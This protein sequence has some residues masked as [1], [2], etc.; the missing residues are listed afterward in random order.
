[1]SLLASQVFARPALLRGGVGAYHSDEWRELRGESGVFG[2]VGQTLNVFAVSR[3]AGLALMTDGGGGMYACRGSRDGWVSALPGSR[4]L[5]LGDGDEA[6]SG[7]HG[8]W[9]RTRD[10]AEYR[11][12]T[13]HC[14]KFS[15]IKSIDLP[16]Q[17]GCWWL[18]VESSSRVETYA[19]VRR[20]RRNCLETVRAA[21]FLI[22]MLAYRR[23]ISRSRTGIPGRLP[24]FLHEIP[25]GSRAQMQGKCEVWL[26]LTSSI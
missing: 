21:T 9:L 4:T 7:L 19:H 15:H 10:A 8:G 17:A 25:L 2:H 6:Q 18:A 3:Y 14:Q 23:C 1:M 22:G 11:P 12:D 26:F 5:E 20:S 24:T 13:S 16:S